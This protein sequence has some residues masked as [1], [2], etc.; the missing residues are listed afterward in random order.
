MQAKHLR[1]GLGCGA[2]L[3]AAC[4]LTGA[5]DLPFEP[6]HN[7]G[8]SVTGAFEGWFANPDGTYSL[9]VGY[10][11]RN[12]KNAVDIPIGPNNRIEPGGPDL[13]QPTHFVPGRN[14]G[15]FTVK[16]PK[17]FGTQRLRWTV[18]ANGKPTV[19][20]LDIQDVYEVSPFVDATGDTPPFIGFSDG[21][22][23]LNGPREISESLSGTVGT[24]VP[25]TAWVADDAKATLSGGGGGGGAP[26][27]RGR[28]KLEPVT[29][30]WT[31]FRGPGTV[32][33]DNAEPVVQKLPL[34]VTPPGT[35]FTG[36][37]T[38]TATFSAPGEYVLDLQ[39][40]DAS[41]Q[42]GNGGFQCCW[43]DAKV[44]ISVKAGAAG[45]GGSESASR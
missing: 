23:F 30:R 28:P 45:Q 6:H 33:F 16:V 17:N 7:A 1:I 21:G 9:L 37:V 14:W 24:P 25:L 3:L 41:T 43:S 27:G 4:A 8:E 34:K 29:V 2:I 26:G 11:N 32:T 18:V 38:N 5:Q 15:M 22:P 10:Y 13:G 40:Y 19:I 35:V 39:A 42:I 20:P 36:K 44:K 31:L 12:L